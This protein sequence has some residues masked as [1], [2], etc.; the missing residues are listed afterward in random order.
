MSLRSPIRII[1]LHGGVFS[2]LQDDCPDYMVKLT[3]VLVS[4][5]CG[6]TVVIDINSNGG[7]A[8]YGMH[9]V[10]LI[11]NAKK[12]GAHIV[13]FA[14]TSAQSSAFSILLACSFRICK[15]YATLMQHDISYDVEYQGYNSTI[16]IVEFN[17]ALA[18]L[19]IEKDYNFIDQTKIT[20]EE[21]EKS[22]RGGGGWTITPQEALYLGMIDKVGDIDISI[23]VG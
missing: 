6:D 7:D 9:I 3:N 11:E 18:K 19:A 12:R 8:A 13:G 14:T 1:K 16:E 22:I 17:E 23:T 15:P 20:Y 2:P 4:A 5:R 10:D 21:F